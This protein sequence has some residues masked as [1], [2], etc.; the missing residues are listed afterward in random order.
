[1]DNV[2]ELEEYARNIL[3][4][5][6][7]CFEGMDASVCKVIVNTIREFFQKYPFLRYTL[8]GLGNSDYLTNYLNLNWYA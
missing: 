6:Y 2:R 5:P 7:V 1:M 4:I 3:E 8:S